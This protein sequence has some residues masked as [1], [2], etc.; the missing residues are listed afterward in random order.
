MWDRGGGSEGEQITKVFLRG[1]L[2]KAIEFCAICQ[3]GLLP[4]RAVRG[5]WKAVGGGAAVRGQSHEGPVGWLLE[6]SGVVGGGWWEGQCGSQGAAA[7][8]AFNTEASLGC[9]MPSTSSL[10][11]YHEG[12]H[13]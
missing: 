1:A 4:Q 11:P 5:Q 12:G 3:Q 10:C 7:A 8:E 13:C 2:P 9:H 6:G